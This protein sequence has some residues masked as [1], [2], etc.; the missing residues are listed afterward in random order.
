MIG[1]DG[2]VT[3]NVVYGGE[4]L[5]Y[6]GT[7]TGWGENQKPMMKVNGI[8]TYTTEE[9]VTPGSYDYKFKPHV[10]DWNESF[11]AEGG[12]ENSTVIIPGIIQQNLTVAAGKTT[13]LPEVVNVIDKEGTKKAVAATYNLKQ[14]SEGVTL[15]DYVLSV[16]KTSPVKQVQL[17]VTAGE[18][19]ALTT[20]QV[21]SE[22]YTYTIN[23]MRPAGDYNDWNLWLWYD[24]KSGEAYTFNKGI[25]NEWAQAVYEMQTQNLNFIIR[26]GND[27]KVREDKVDRKITMPAGSKNVEVWLMQG[28]S[29][30]YYEKPDVSARVINA[31]MDNT[32]EI[33]VNLSAAPENINSFVLKD[34]SGQVI[35]T[36]ATKMGET[37]LKLTV[38]D[39][40][41]IDVSQIYTVGS[42]S[43]KA[44]TVTMRGILDDT[45]YY[46]EGNDLLIQVHKVLSKYGHLQQKR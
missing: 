7:L 38:Q 31:F 5:Y 24:G 27:W 42:P 29:I 8:F 1:E 41:T 19:T 12:T 17:E 23:Y 10:D 9:P 11:N 44:A 28:D 32:E 4:T 26:K 20:V 13:T 21:V 45:K 33:I 37:R 36:V 35:E 2:R 30:V 46:Y 14:E 3:F 16:D 43:F 40:G 39:A 6:V 34:Q 22:L 25:Q 15:K 18:L